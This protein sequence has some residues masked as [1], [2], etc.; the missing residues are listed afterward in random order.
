MPAHASWECGVPVGIALVVQVAVLASWPYVGLLE[1]SQP[2]LLR[3]GLAL[4]GV[5]ALERQHGYRGDAEVVDEV[6]VDACWVELAQVQQR[7]PGARLFE[8]H[9]ILLELSEVVAA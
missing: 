6:G 7:M 8:L 5:V 1:L 2:F 9:V 3:G 4:L